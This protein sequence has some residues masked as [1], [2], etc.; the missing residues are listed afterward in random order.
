[1]R[2]RL[3]AVL[4]VAVGA[5]AVSVPGALANHLHSLQLG[6]GRCV[7]LAQDGNERYVV[8]PAASFQ[9][10]SEPSTTANPH[11]LHVHVHRGEPGQQQAMG[12]Y[13]T[14]SDP[15]YLTGDYVND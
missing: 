6:N 8:L 14:P 11:P 15:C 3:L 13:G 4:V 12:V 5:L 2:L 9:N 7:I 10:T 1:M